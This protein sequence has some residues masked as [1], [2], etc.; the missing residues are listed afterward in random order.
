MPQ[1]A[2]PLVN[3]RQSNYHSR[4][5]R[6]LMRN[7]MIELPKLILA[8]GSPRR[9]QILSSVGWEF[10][11]HVPDIDESEREDETPEDYVLRLA[12]EKEEKIAVDHPGRI[13]LAADTTVVAEHNILGKPLDMP[14]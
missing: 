13:V 6:R 8:S 9:S 7:A 2:V 10:E 12:V 4:Q 3:Y 11:K 14:G 1:K 5:Q